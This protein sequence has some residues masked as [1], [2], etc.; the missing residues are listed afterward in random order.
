MSAEALSPRA[1]KAAPRETGETLTDG[2]NQ[3]T[4][5]QLSLDQFLSCEDQRMAALI[6]LYQSHCSDGL[7]PTSDEIRPEEIFAT[8]M[9]NRTHLIR[10]ESSDDQIRYAVWAQDANFDG[11]RN[12]QN[13]HMQ[14]LMTD[15]AYGLMFKAV[16]KQLAAARLH[17]RPAYYEMKG[18][19]S[20]CCGRQI[21]AAPDGAGH[22]QK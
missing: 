1:N 10:I 16:K 21:P 22:D 14:N 19:T 17:G 7:P 15:A 3:I 18:E 6:K 20:K 9:M 8:G 4:S 12:L 11:Y 13:A 2:N 5:I